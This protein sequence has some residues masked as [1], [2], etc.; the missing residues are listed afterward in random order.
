MPKLGIQ[1]EYN[2]KHHLHIRYNFSLGWYF[3][4]YALLL[5]KKKKNRKRIEMQCKWEIH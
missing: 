1:S 3:Y 5:T 4:Y 2:K